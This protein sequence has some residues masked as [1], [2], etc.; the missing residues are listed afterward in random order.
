MT[1][2]A[3]WIFVHAI[4]VPFTAPQG[5]SPFPPRSMISENIFGQDLETG[6]RFY[7][8][9]FMSLSLSWGKGGSHRGFAVFVFF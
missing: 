1:V 6:K 9:F 5:C 4:N 7:L 3:F 2:H 8:Y